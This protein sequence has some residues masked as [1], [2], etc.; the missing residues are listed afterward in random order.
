MGKA[1]LLT[2]ILNYKTPEMTVRAA[3]AALRAMQGV[4]GEILIV[5]N[6]SDDGSFQVISD[7]IKAKGWH[8]SNRVRIVDAG[9]NGGFGAGNNFGIRTGLSDGT[10]PDYIYVL[11]SDAF[12]EKGAIAALLDGLENDATLG[13]TGSRI[14]G[15]DGVPHQTAFRFP[16][17]ASEFEGAARFGPIS[18]LFKNKTVPMPLPER[19]CLVDW[20]AGASVMMRREM[21]DQIGLFDENFFL[22]FEET[23]LCLRVKRGGWKIKYLPE[24]RVTH[25]GGVST[26][27]G[28]WHRIPEYWLDSRNYYFTK[29]HGNSYAMAATLAHL[30]GGLIW[31]SRRVLQGNPKI[32]PDFFLRD[33]ARHSVLSLLA[34]ITQNSRKTLRRQDNI[35]R[36]QA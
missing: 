13:M 24:S 16:T 29:S 35:K 9:R 36:R 7:A 34:L 28:K 17:I 19:A 18:R 12:P 11:N 1:T 20:V 8:K 2:V 4:A 23:E 15:E 25:I 31:Q 14:L 33:L 5:D 26:N 21:L 3:S 22:Y 30:A 32:D 6:L 27:G 10:Q